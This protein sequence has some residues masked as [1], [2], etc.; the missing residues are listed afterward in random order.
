M[1]RIH[2]P[3]IGIACIAAASC[4]TRS[5]GRDSELSHEPSWSAMLQSTE[6]NSV[7]GSAAV[8]GVDANS[9]SR[10]VISLAGSRV[11]AMHPWDIHEGVCG[12]DGSIVGNSSL[13]PPVPIGSAG[14]A[15]MSLELP[16]QLRSRSRYYV[17]VHEGPARR[18]IVACGPL[19]RDAPMVV[20]R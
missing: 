18:R 14:A 12:G 5:G 3:I 20:G 6:G 4:V 17:N 9:R 15:T 10:V 8:V 7:R 2:I 1:R 11:N 19:L 13:Y 16:I